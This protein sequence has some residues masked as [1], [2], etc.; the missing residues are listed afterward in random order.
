M[1]WLLQVQ[2]PARAPVWRTWSRYVA[3]PRGRHCFAARCSHHTSRPYLRTDDTTASFAFHRLLLLNE[4]ATMMSCQCGTSCILG[5]ARDSCRS[6]WRGVDL[7][8]RGP[9]RSHVA[10]LQSLSLPPTR[11][12]PGVDDELQ[13]VLV[14]VRR[15]ASGL[16]QGGMPRSCSDPGT[17]CPRSDP[18]SLQPGRHPLRCLHGTRKT[19]TIRAWCTRA[20]AV[21]SVRVPR[22]PHS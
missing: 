15:C 12:Y 11:S 6:L 2:V 22:V 18:C 5:V 16:A 13:G 20:P 8:R 1:I 14:A 17:R 21:C 7:A 19:G 3:C 9:S 10:L 4:T